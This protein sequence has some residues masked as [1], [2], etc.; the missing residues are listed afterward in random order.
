[1]QSAADVQARAA[2]ERADSVPRLRALEVR[3]ALDELES[4]MTHALKNPLAGMVLASTRIRRAVGALAGQEKLAAICAHL[5]DSVASLNDEIARFDRLEL[6]PAPAP[7]ETDVRVLL[8]GRTPTALG[9]ELAADL[10][11]VL[12]DPSFVRAAL[13]CL[14]DE[15]ARAAPPGEAT[16]VAARDG[17]DGRVHLDVGRGSPPVEGEGDREL[18]RPLKHGRLDALGV[19]IARRLLEASGCSLAVDRVEHRVR[20]RVSLP[21]AHGARR[22]RT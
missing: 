8:D 16:P 21:V 15:A 18:L 9:P 3:A 7:C 22:E 10:P 13:G 14:L 12:V 6:L 5:S 4:E 17:G 20:A 1:M 19:G 2:A 11:R